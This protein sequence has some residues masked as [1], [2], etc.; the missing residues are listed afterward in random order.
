[1]SAERRLTV[2]SFPDSDKTIDNNIENANEV[3]SKMM[4][5]IKIAKDG[6]GLENLRTKSE[7]IDLL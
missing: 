1:M 4:K 2:W 7:N 3:T 5:I 6:N